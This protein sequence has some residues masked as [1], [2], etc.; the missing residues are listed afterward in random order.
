MLG[1]L[2]FGR[3]HQAFGLVARL[4]R[5][6]ALLVV[7]RVGFGVL[8][9]LLDLGLGETAGGLDGDLLF[10][11]SRLVARRHVDDAVGVDV[12]RDLDLWHA[13]RSRWDPLKVEVTEQLV[14]ARHLALALKHA[15]RHGRLVVVSGREHLRF[16]RRDGRVAIDQAREHAAQRLDAERQR[17][18]VEQHDV[19]HV[20]LQH[21]ALDRRADGDD[22]IRV[23]ALVR[24]LAEEGF[25]RLLHFRHARHA[26]D[27]DDFVD[28]AHGLAG[29]GQRLLAR[30]HRALHQ[31]LDEG[32]ELG[33]RQL[34][35]EVDR[36]RGTRCDIWLGDVHLRDGRQLLLDLF[37]L[38]ADALQ[39]HQVL[40]EID[41]VLL[42]ELVADIVDQT[43]VEVL[44]AEEGVAIG[45]Q[46]FEHAI[47]DLEDRD[48]ERAAT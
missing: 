25:H 43:V 21:A 32:L 13:A 5:L 17:G 4:D 48:V 38:G 24:L 10:F 2:L 22:F 1:Q 8:H 12:E 41:A 27:E 44:A 39:R 16:F 36:A 20:A 23:D 33:A 11:R 18:H 46:H 28:L 47:A 29:V 6:A 3:V 26:A 7:C 30:V 14:V 37:G 35:V 45:R 34:H 42:L 19:F 15:D 31:V 9:H 40:A